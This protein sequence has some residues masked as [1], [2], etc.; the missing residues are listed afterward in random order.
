MKSV[1]RR[2]GE[3]VAAKRLSEVAKLLAPDFVYHAPGFPEIRGPREW[4][5]LTGAF[6]ANSPNLQFGI[7]E[8]VAEEQTV[9]TRYTW[10][11]VFERE[12]M[13]MSPNGQELAVHA[14]QIDHMD[15]SGKITEQWLFD[16]YLGLF[17]QLRAVPIALLQDRMEVPGGIGERPVPVLPGK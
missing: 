1:A 7:D 14:V 4:E 8:Q 17:R 6:F 3:G 2:F 12:F 10:R 16:D 15:E 13:G 11:T 9:V 5:A